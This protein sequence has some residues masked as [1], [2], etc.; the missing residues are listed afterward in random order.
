[1]QSISFEISRFRS[2]GFWR[3]QL[4]RIH[5]GCCAALNSSL[6]I[7]LCNRIALI[8]EINP[9]HA[10]YFH[11]LHSSSILILL[12]YSIPIVSLYF[13]SEWKTRWIP[14]SW[15]H[16]KPADLDL[17]CFQEWINPG[18]AGQGLRYIFKFII[19]PRHEISNN[20]VCV[21]SKASDQPAHMHSL[22]RAFASC[23]NILW[24]LSYCPKI[25]WSFLA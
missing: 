1:M 6:W 10:E 24:I 19:E 22:I 5:T 9:C 3:S 23:L 17:Q 7:K 16:Q 13:Q 8:S 11:V 15:L 25:I 14:I 18:S 12:T 21:T 2:A 20:V 4:F